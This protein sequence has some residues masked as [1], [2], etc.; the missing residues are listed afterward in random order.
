MIR[1]PQKHLI[2]RSAKNTIKMHRSHYHVAFEILFLFFCSHMDTVLL[3]PWVSLTFRAEKAALSRK[4]KFLVFGNDRGFW[5][6][7]SIFF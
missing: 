1:T 6:K 3:P 4:T 2:G 7:P 5:R